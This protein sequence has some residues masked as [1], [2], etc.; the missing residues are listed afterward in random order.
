MHSQDAPTRAGWSPRALPALVAIVVGGLGLWWLAGVKDVDAYRWPIA[1]FAGGNALGAVLA[2]STDGPRRLADRFLGLRRVSATASV[3]LAA[4]LVVGAA[5]Y[6]RSNAAQGEAD[7]SWFGVVALLVLL[8]GLA[9]WSSG[10]AAIM[11]LVLPVLLIIDGFAGRA[12]QGRAGAVFTGLAILG[13][14]PVGVCAVQLTGNGP[15]P[16]GIGL[17]IGQLSGISETSQ[18]S[19]VWTSRVVVVVWALLLV[20][21]RQTARRRV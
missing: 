17:L 7:P 16:G 2:Y 13:T 21:V 10:V 5:C 6:P 18:L 19:W 14:I 15:R 12:P 8:G 20:G 11:L 4:Q 9:A 3:A 1:T